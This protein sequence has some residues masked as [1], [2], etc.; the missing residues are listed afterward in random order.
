MKASSPQASARAEDGAGTSARANCVRWIATRRACT[1]SPMPPSHEAGSQD[2][3]QRQHRHYRVNAGHDVREPLVCRQD[4]RVDCGERDEADGAAEQ[5]LCGGV[6][7]DPR[8]RRREWEA[9]LIVHVW[10][11]S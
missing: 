10:W 5:A 8:S 2:H 7:P 6:L 11:V 9:S 3:H 1:L 4:E